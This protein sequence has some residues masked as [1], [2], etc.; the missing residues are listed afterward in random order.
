[1]RHQLQPERRAAK[2]TGTVENVL[3]R[4]DGAIEVHM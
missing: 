3:R 2:Y 1:V 4:D